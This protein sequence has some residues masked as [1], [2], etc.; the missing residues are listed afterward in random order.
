[1]SGVFWEREICVSD[2]RG[3]LTVKCSFLIRGPG[4]FSI[5]K[6]ND[7]TPSQPGWLD[8]LK[9]GLSRTSSQLR[10]GLSDLW[11]RDRVDEA[12][13]ESLED[14]LLMAD[15]GPVAT[16]RILEQLRLEAR[17]S[18]IES[19]AQLKDALVQ[20][21]VNQV[22]PLE[23]ALSLDAHRP[24]VIMTVGVNGAGKTTTIGKLARRFSDEGKTVLLAA[25]DTFRA[26]ARE[27]LATWGE[28]SGITVLAQEGADPAAVVFDAVQSARARNIDV[29]IADTAGRLPTQLHLMDELKKIQRV[30]GKAEEGAPHE[31][32]L[33]LDGNTGQNARAQIEAFDKALNI[34]GLVVTKLDGTARGGALIG[35]AAQDRVIPVRYIGVG[36]GIEDLQP[37]SAEAFVEALLQ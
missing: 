7:Q 8:R 5:F 28:R 19:P 23:K 26:A 33:V 10:L 35:M 27:Q 31:V 11:S 22:R 2:S 25:G 18:R 13:F 6:K 32:L 17:K 16:G 37:F 20:A 15:V 9:A 34:T 36:E 24:L 12:W 4:M 29:V 1:V 21:L 14:T 30:I 3:E